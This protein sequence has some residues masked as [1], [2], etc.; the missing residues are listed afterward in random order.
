MT[1]NFNEELIIRLEEKIILGNKLNEIK[2]LWISLLNNF[3]NDISVNISYNKVYT[4]YQKTLIDVKQ[5]ERR[6]IFL[7]LLTNKE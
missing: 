5:N 4:D 1:L 6:I 2:L 3:K 7:K